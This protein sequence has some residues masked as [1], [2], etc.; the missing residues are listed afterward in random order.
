MASAERQGEAGPSV[1]DAT[2]GEA[3]K[4]AVDVLYSE[5]GHFVAAK[6]W[7]A[8]NYRLGVPA[9]LIGAAAGASILG[10]A[11]TLIPGLLA[12]L[13]AALTALITFLNPSE[14]A[15]QHHRAGVDYARLR[16]QIR[17]FVQIDFSAMAEEELR[18]R[19]NDL[20]DRVGTVQGDALPIPAGAHRGAYA[21]IAKGSADYT[22]AELDAATGPVTG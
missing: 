13:A 5:K 8:W 4:L 20:T 19:L 15:A 14:R 11:P 7:R 9:A 18:N 1:R 3:R 16:R 21:S 10:N 6:S 2:L 12:L 22:V 17:Q